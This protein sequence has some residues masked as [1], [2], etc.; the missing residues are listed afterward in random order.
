MRTTKQYKSVTAS[1]VILVNKV[2]EHKLDRTI[3]VTYGAYTAEKKKLEYKLLGQQ[4]AGGGLMHAWGS[5]MDKLQQTLQLIYTAEGNQVRVYNLPDI[6]QRWEDEFRG[7]LKKDYSMRGGKEML[8]ATDTLLAD[9]PAF[10]RNF[11]AY[12][13]HRLLLHP[14]AAG[15]NML[16]PFT[17]TNFFGSGI[18]LCLIL[19]ALAQP[20]GSVKVSATVDEDRQ[21]MIALTHM[22]REITHAYNLLVDLQ[23]EMEETHKF[24][25]EGLPSEADC[26]LSV[27]AADGLY[28]VILAHQLT[29]IAPAVGT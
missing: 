1:R 10:E 23:V 8:E 3:E 9:G 13:A 15:T 5:E 11:L 21:D 25:A 18:D 19:E 24:C 16:H 12:N 27:T 14:Y 28:K 17:L 26:Y 7:R 4:L 20:D 2:T 6:Q 22:V 29:E